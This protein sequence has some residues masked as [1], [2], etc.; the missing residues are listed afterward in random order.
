MRACVVVAVLCCALIAQGARAAEAGPT[1]SFADAN[2]GLERS[3][4]LVR[5]V[6]MDFD[7]DEKVAP[8]TARVVADSIVAELRKLAATSVVGMDEVR[9]MLA[10]ESTRQEAGCSEGSSCLADIA[11]ALGA[12]VLIT[13]RIS[14]LNGASV[15][16]VRRINPATASVT[17]QVE[18]HLTDAG[19]EEL[20]A[21][22]GP[23]IEELFPEVMVKAGQTRGVPPERARVLNPPPLPVWSTAAVGV[24]SVVVAGA[25]V[26]LG[27]LSHQAYASGQALVDQSRTTPT[28]GALVAA[29]EQQGATLATAANVA[30][31]V[32]VGV[33]V[34]GG[35][36]ALFT[37]WTG[38]G[39]ES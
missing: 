34:A 7:V 15:F 33:A 17:A 29:Q 8:R 28:S 4:R 22:V 2:A 27:V 1:P 37:D 38:V 25:G 6:V 24:G 16:S 12:D 30:F 10:A 11:D 13:G 23:A 26:A 19:G 18:E 20:L 39:Q 21:A 32:A 35:V 31:A 3:K 5:I 36:M 9:S 14:Q